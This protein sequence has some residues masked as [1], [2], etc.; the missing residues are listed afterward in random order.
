MWLAVAGDQRET[1][2][3]KTT[4]SSKPKT[5]GQAAVET[6]RS[7]TAREW[8]KHNTRNRNWRPDRIVQYAHDMRPG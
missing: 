2:K 1:Q 8:L 4:R 5:S 3:S 7:S 6:V